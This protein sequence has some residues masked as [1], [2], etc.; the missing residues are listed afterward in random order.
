[1]QAKDRELAEAQ[2]QL[3]EKV[4]IILVCENY[5]VSNSLLQEEQLQYKVKQ[6]KSSE[7]ERVA[8]QQQLTRKEAELIRAEETIRREQQQIHERVSQHAQTTLI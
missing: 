1:M 2:Q 7:W 5:L 3:R 4:N 6:L 8:V